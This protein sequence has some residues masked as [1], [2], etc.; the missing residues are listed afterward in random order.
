V[1]F[2]EYHGRPQIRR[3]L[4][5]SASAIEVILERRETEDGGGG[6]GEGRHPKESL[7]KKIGGIDAKGLKGKKENL[8]LDEPRR[9]WR[10][11]HSVLDGAGL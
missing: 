2:K 6:K 7:T 1:A 4:R 3:G 11:K 10:K 8:F 9:H 5:G